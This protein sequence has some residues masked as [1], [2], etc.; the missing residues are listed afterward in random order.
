MSECVAKCSVTKCM[1]FK[2][3]FVS[4]S[5]MSLAVV[6]KLCQFTNRCVLFSGSGHRLRFITTTIEVYES[7]V[8]DRSDARM[9]RM[10]DCFLFF[11]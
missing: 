4:K 2:N 11:F 7:V 3:E 5:F 9:E 1:S 10:S 6:Y 8:P